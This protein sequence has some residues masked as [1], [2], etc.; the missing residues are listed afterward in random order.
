M[1]ASTWIVRA[2]S[3][4]ALLTLAACGGGGGGSGGGGTGGGGSGG[5]SA[6]PPTISAQPA[7]ATVADGASASFSTVAAGNAPLVYQWRRNDTDLVDGTG[8]SGATSAALTLT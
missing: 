3:L 2:S 8:V 7:A 1:S 5:G 6:V 4:I